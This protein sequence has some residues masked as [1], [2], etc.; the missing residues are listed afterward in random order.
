[1]GETSRPFV[2]ASVIAVL[3]VGGFLVSPPGPA[4][5]TPPTLGG[6]LPNGG[7]AIRG[8]TVYNVSWN[9]THDGDPSL[10]TTLR[11]SIFGPGAYPMFLTADYFP[12]G[13]ASVPW[14]VPWWSTAGARVQACATAWDGGRSCVESAGNFSIG[15]DPPYFDLLSPS[16]GANN[17]PLEESLLFGFNPRPDTAQVMFQVT[18]PMAFTL[19]WTPGTNFTFLTLTHASPFPYCTRVHVT[20]WVGTA[21]RS[22]SFMSR[23][24]APRILSIT[25]PS[26]PTSPIIVVFS[27]PMDTASVVW[28]VTPAI[29]LVPAWSAHNT[30]LNL[31]PAASFAPC[32]TYTFAILAGRSVYGDPLSPA[33]PV[34]NPISF[35]MGCPLP[36]PRAL[37]VTLA[38]PDLLLSW[39]A[40]PGATEYRVYTSLDR[41]AA[42][43]AWTLSGTV[44]GTTCT[45]AGDA[46]DALTR[47]YVVRGF[48]GARE[49]ANSTMGV[50]RPLSFGHVPGQTN[51]AW[52]SLP[53]N[54]TYRRASDIANALGP[55]K[56]D[57]VGKWD[58]AAQTSIVYYHGQ[59]GWR[60]T[61]FPIAPGDGLY[62]GT[63]SAFPWT[64]VGTDA[65]V[66]LAFPHN[67]PPKASKAWFGVPYTGVYSKAS[68]IAGELGPGKV[69]EIGRWDP[70]TQTAELWSWTGM[71]W[72]GTDFAIEPGAGVYVI[73]A[74]DFTWTPGLLTPEIP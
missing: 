11:Y 51:I 59:G 26:T 43:S 42:W 39:R 55:G 37:T 31:T 74:F 67:P 70:A 44:T 21:S 14:N 27:E 33:G 38:P 19:T 25:P 1:M 24:V 4:P 36:A 3:L 49:G 9:A 22:W 65:D 2:C 17:V 52:F 23:C 16:N 8:D 6:L 13:G 35:S 58:P 32:T 45:I 15:A 30:V 29:L 46:A 10:F 62:L 73:V 64:V 28:T 34:P 48:D 41:F 47:Y 72:S 69:T 7:E 61:D 60:G 63:T 18:P 66:P 71:T 20:L 57:L 12:T 56:A 5:A 40:V 50:K 53:Y 68:D 54:S